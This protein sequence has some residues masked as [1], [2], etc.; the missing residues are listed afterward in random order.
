MS[1]KLLANLFSTAQ[2]RAVMNDPEHAKA[3]I[4]FCTHSFSSCN[5][6]VTFHAALVLFNYLLTF[7]NTSRRPYV[8]V[9]GLALRAIVKVLSNGELVDKDTLVALLLCE[10]RILFKNHDMVQMVENAFKPIF[11]ETHEK[12]KERQGAVPEVLQ[13]IQDVIKMVDLEDK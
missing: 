10:C 8:A 5:H 6:K 1:L 2:G 3:L 7:E 12:L 13:A 9:L 4:S 11:K